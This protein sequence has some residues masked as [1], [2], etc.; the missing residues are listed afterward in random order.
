MIFTC[1]FDSSSNEITPTTTIE[2]KNKNKFVELLLIWGQKQ[3]NYS[4]NSLV[5]YMFKESLLLIT[6]WS[7]NLAMRLRP[8]QIEK[9]RVISKNN[10]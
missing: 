5:T 9:K 8:K 7:K 6:P 2:T 10:V 1:Q 4:F 3:K